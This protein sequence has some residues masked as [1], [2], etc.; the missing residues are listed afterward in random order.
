[1]LVLVLLMHAILA[2]LTVTCT[3][4]VDQYC[5]SSM[6]PPRVPRSCPL[7]STS[8]L[9]SSLLTLRAWLCG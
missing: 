2:Y 6:L 9:P 8:T 3:N 7:V 1:M 5:R 4:A